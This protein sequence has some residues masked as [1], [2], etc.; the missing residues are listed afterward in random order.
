MCFNISIIS[1]QTQKRYLVIYIPLNL[2]ITVIH[3]LGI[4]GIACHPNMNPPLR[5]RGACGVVCSSRS[6]EV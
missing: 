2:T 4:L 5:C 6:E 3:C 1:K